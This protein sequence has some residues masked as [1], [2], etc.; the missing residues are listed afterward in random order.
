M[1]NLAMRVSKREYWPIGPLDWR[2]MKKKGLDSGVA[3]ASVVFTIV[4]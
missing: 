2:L 4:G 3:S 1:Q